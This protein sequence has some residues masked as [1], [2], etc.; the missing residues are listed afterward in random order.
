VTAPLTG[1]ADRI[2]VRAGEKISFKVSSVGPGPYN[3]MLVRIVRGDPNP[4]GPP[5]KL[6][7]QSE[8]FDGRFASRQQHAWPGSYALIERAADVKLPEAL[9]VEALIWPTLPEDGPQTVISRSAD[10]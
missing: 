4:G 7:D 8:L 1:Y 6:E 2:S 5:Q 3:A 10:A 9:A